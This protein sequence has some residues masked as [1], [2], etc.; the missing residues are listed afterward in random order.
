M[1]AKRYIKYGFLSFFFLIPT[2]AYLENINDIKTILTNCNII[3]CTGNINLKMKE[4]L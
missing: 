3:D 2:K 1:K 4:I